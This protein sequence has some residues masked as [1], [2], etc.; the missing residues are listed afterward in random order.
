MGNKSKFVL[1][2]NR[3]YVWQDGKKLEIGKKTL[4]MGILNVTPDSFSDGGR[5]NSVDN[6]VQH[7]LEM[8]VDGADII[9]I[10]AE[11]S[12][13]GF[14]PMSAQEEIERLKP[15]LAAVLPACPVPVSVDTFKAETAA[16]AA[17][18]GVHII[19]DIWGLQYENEPGEMADVAAQY[20]LPVV[21]MH[22]SNS[23]EYPGDII[24]SM[25]AFFQRT[26]DI[27]AKAGLDGDKL[28]LDPG[29][30]FG[31]KAEKNLEVIN[32]LHEL[33]CFAGKRYPMLL[34]A[35]RKSFIGHALDLP[36]EQRLEATGA[37]C[38]IGI[39]KG[40][41]IVRVHDVM[42]VGRMCSMAD[43]ILTAGRRGAGNILQES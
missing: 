11:S 25:R 3:Q 20:N 28:I 9:D 2:E 15:F 18:Q 16:F 13:P 36:V 35:S 23:S 6:A 38:V 43:A 31:K 5:W 40:C 1:P 33:K 41:N 7:M 39:V 17:E 19:N 32:R 8:A 26:I 27:A 21:A 22:N 34:G 37:A 14:V 24:D 10:G 42:A 29:I 4:V 12:R 30:G